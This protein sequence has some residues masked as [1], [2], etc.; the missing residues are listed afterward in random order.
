MELSL[1]EIEQRIAIVAENL[2]VLTEE[3]AVLSG[4]GDNEIINQQIDQQQAVYD[5]LNSRL[6]SLS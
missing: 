5:E 4:A 2:R 6:A 3:A 1:S